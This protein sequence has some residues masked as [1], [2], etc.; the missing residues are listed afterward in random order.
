MGSIGVEFLGFTL[1]DANGF[2][3]VI[4]GNT[5]MGYLIRSSGEYR[6]VKLYGSLDGISLVWEYG[7][8]LGYSDESAGGFKLFLDE[9]TDFCF[10]LYPSEGYKNV[11]IYGCNNFVVV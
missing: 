3:P 2:K 6:D 9:A 5:E 7:T 10:Q 4:D 11:K 8:V 1:G